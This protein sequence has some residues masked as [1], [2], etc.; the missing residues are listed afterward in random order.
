LQNCFVLPFFLAWLATTK[1][2]GT[3]TNDSK[4]SLQLSFVARHG[5]EMSI[6][7]FSVC[8]IMDVKRNGSLKETILEL[9]FCISTEEK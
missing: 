1:Q 9:P 8:S 3:L 6:D 2:V 7:S 5:Q 4:T